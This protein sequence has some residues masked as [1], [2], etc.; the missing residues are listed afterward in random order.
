GA[1]RSLPVGG[2]RTRRGRR[3]GAR[4][5]RGAPGRDRPARCGRTDPA[6]PRSPRRRRAGA[7]AAARR[8][9]M[10]GP[11]P[12]EKNAAPA[13]VP[14]LAETAAWLA[15]DKPAGIAVVPAR[16][17]P[18]GDSL[19]AR[20]EAARGERLW[21]VHRLDRETSGVVLFARTAEAHR[22]LSLAFEHREVTKQYRAW[23]CGAPEP[24]TGTIDLPL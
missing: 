7:G 5:T 24:A 10:T 1:P 2:G 16:G 15:V 4:G 18:F 17:E 11:G 22:T 23:T 20:L 21:V 3:G 9:R 8:R 19:R 14:V 12:A 6:R 13:A